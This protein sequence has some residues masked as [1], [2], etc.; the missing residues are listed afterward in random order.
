MAKVTDALD[1][2]ANPA[3][4]P[5]QPFCVVF[6][7][8]DFLARG[9]LAHLRKSVL[10]EEDADLSLTTF[11]GRT[12]ELADVLGELETVAMFG[13]DRRMVVVEGADDFIKKFRG[14]LEDHAAETGG[15][16]VLVL[17]PKTW[18]SN[19][20]LYKAV[21]AKGLSIKCAAP[22]MAQLGSWLRSWAKQRHGSKIAPA[23]SQLLVELVGP[24]LG[25]LDQELAKLSLSAGAGKPITAELVGKMVGTWRTK[26]AWQMLEAAMAGNVGDALSQLDRLLLAGE[27]PIAI[28]AQISSNLRRFAAATRIILQDEA[29]GRRPVLRRALETAGVKGFVLA[30]SQ[31]ELKRLGRHRGAKLYRWL[32]E[33]DL[34]LKGNSALPPRLIIERLIVRISAAEAKEKG[35]AG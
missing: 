17:L 27:H 23:A 8:E 5:A 29:A 18:P 2:L 6:G 26:T 15:S 7:D 32:L 22:K 20:R 13:G 25:L 1:Y 24:E 4:F 19:T 31:E 28:L 35:V 12:A 21:A 3:D 11:E 10:G 16:G 14:E 34:D 30:R 33:A 9:V